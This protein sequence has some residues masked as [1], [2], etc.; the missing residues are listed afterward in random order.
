MK[1]YNNQVNIKTGGEHPGTNP[2]DA[3]LQTL[4]TTFLANLIVLYFN[5]LIYYY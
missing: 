1:K 4:L 3:S 5:N 2:L